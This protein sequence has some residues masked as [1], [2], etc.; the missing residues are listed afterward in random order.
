MDRSET[1]ERMKE[2]NGIK[3][4]N[5]TNPKSQE[6]TGVDVAFNYETHLCHVL[7]NRSRIMRYRTIQIV[8]IS[9]P[10]GTVRWQFKRAFKIRRQSRD[11]RLSDQSADI[12]LECYSK[13]QVWVTSSVGRVASAHPIQGARTSP[14][15]RLTWSLSA[16]PSVS[17]GVVHA[18]P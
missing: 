7:Y 17:T 4:L 11:R 6:Y 15:T 1:N 3:A 5:L 18:G 13:R 16:R 8:L 12:H 2:R 10:S 14:C 9:A